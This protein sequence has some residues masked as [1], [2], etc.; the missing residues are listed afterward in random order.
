VTLSRR[1]QKNSG[2]MHD[3]EGHE[4]HSCLQSH[5]INAPSAADGL[6]TQQNEASRSL[7]LRRPGDSW[8]KFEVLKGRGFSR[9][10]QTLRTWGL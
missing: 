10:V 3:R 8:H 9:A 1:L 6:S 7:L 2:I 5:K 4:F